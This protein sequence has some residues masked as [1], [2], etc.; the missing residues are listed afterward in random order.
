MLKAMRLGT[1]ILGA[2]SII[3]LGTLSASAKTAQSQIAFKPDDGTY[4]VVRVARK[5]DCRAICEADLQCR[6]AV[7]YQPDIRKSEAFCR[8]NNGFGENP[9]FP[10]QP[11][12]PLDLHRAVQDLNNY[13]ARYGL[14]PVR[15]APKLIEASRIHADDLAQA[16]IISHNGT[17][18][19]THGD[20]ANRVGYNFLIAGENVATG[21]KS[22]EQVFK[23]WQESPGHNENLL[24]PDVS[25][26]GIALV[27]E[28]R[29]T[30][31][32]YWAMLVAEPMNMSFM[33]ASKL[34]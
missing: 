34:P 10:Q 8:L 15:L 2:M 19:S 20:R 26:F 23:D 13:R 18:G 31:S 6:G 25:E 33:H 4:K 21:Q 5:D 30:Y 32:T 9:V 17:D 28:P 7:T 16:G 12:K 22:W 29:T 3:A 24:L 14:K 11:P 27:Y 1:L